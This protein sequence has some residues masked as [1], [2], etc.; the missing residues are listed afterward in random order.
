MLY[1]KQCEECKGL[2]FHIET[3]NYEVTFICTNCLCRETYDSMQ[4][5]SECLGD[6]K[7]VEE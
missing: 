1:Y 6:T 3:G 7:E 2:K 4:A 5:L